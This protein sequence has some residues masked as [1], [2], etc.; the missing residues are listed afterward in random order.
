MKKVPFDAYKGNQGKKIKQNLLLSGKRGILYQFHISYITL[1]IL[2]V[3]E[4]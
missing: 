2:F 4:D 1:K 3:R